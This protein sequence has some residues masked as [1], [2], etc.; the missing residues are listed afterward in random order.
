MRVIGV[1]HAPRVAFGQAVF[2]LQ[3]DFSVS[4]FGQETELSLRDFAS[5]VGQHNVCSS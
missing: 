1:F 5:R 4:E 2:D 3:A